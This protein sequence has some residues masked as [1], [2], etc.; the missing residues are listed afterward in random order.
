MTRRALLPSL[1]AVGALGLAACGDETA[2]TRSCGHLRGGG[3]GGYAV[4]VEV[5]EGDVPCRVTHHVLRSYYRSTHHHIRGHARIAGHFYCR[6]WQSDQAVCLSRF[7]P[8]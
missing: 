8:P 5:L 1:L 3:P 6:R 7:G 2:E 4:R